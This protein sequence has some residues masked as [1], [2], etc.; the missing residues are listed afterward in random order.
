MFSQDLPLPDFSLPFPND[1]PLHR[2]RSRRFEI[3]TTNEPSVIDSLVLQ[4]LMTNYRQH[5]FDNLIIMDARFEYEFQGGHIKASW[6]VCGIVEMQKLYAEFCDC[7]SCV[8]FHC[9]FS[10]DRGPYLMGL[11]R[12][13]DREL[14][15][16]PNLSYPDVFLLEGGY[17]KFY[18]DCPDLCIGGYVPMRQ[19]Q[20]VENGTLKDCYAQY[21][22]Q[23]GRE[24]GIQRSG[25]DGGSGKRKLSAAAFQM[26]FAFD[27][28]EL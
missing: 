22:V 21:I 3:K 23:S 1:S 14:N 16:Y 15:R 10:T 26:K 17:K 27:G 6:N 11:F 18:E 19:P 20:F 25:F 28:C 5:G 8:V 4:D 13:Y 7:H 12:A 2:T 24:R 9:E